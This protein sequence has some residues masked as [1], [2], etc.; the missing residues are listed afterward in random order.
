MESQRSSRLSFYDAGAVI[1]GPIE[2]RKC[3]IAINVP[4][5][6]RPSIQLKLGSEF[7]PLFE[8]EAIAFSQWPP[9]GPGHYELFL[10]CNEIRES[11]PITVLPT[12]FSES[13]CNQIVQEITETLPTRLATQLIKCG[14]QISPPASRDQKSEF[15][16]E[17]IRLRDAIMGTKDRL[18]M[19]Q[20]LAILERDCVR[21]LIPKLEVRSVEKVRRP[22]ISRLPQAMSMPGNVLSSSRL[23]QMYDT[24][25]DQSFEAYENRLV[26]AYVL[27]L[28]S[29]LSRLQ[30]KLKA[31]NAPRAVANEVDNLA[32]EFHLAFMRATFLREIRNASITSVRITMVLLKNP[33]YRAVLQGYLALSQQSSVTIEESALSAPLNNFPYLYQRWAGLKLFSA[34]LQVCAE[35]NYRCTN[36]HW[37]RSFNKSTTLQ[38]MNDGRPAVQLWSDR[39]GLLVSYVPWTPNGPAATPATTAP[40]GVAIFIEAPGQV[41][42]ALLFDPKYWVNPTDPS[43]N[44]PNADA[45]KPKRKS[46]KTIADE[47]FKIRAALDPLQN[48]IEA[49]ARFKEQ[50]KGME[51]A[52]EIVYASIMFP[53]LHKQLGFD[54]EGIPAHPGDGDTLN[55]YLCDVLRHFIP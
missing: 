44:D 11:K 35:K 42:K 21:I 47:N 25:V 6:L 5:E 51:N 1:T 46:K 41:G 54:I 34:L 20:I 50:I 7:L 15:E 10:A 23:Y 27:A 19:M 26:K 31:A 38:I 52:S 48:D 45:N 30:A 8:N 32:N 39:T 40:T 55:K 18:G 4:R 37:V 33:A 22:D 17:F 2:G 43:A 13:E 9:L 36:H 24:T 28:R 12:Y 16:Q 53:G 29:R 3:G 49:V 14:A